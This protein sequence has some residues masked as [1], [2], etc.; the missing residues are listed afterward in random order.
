MRPKFTVSDMIVNKGR[1][2]SDISDELYESESQSGS[3]SKTE[4]LDAPDL[5]AQYS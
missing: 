1:Y 4:L 2:S 3:S 5:L